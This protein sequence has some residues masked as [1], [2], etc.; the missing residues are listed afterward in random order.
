MVKAEQEYKDML[1]IG[2]SFLTV[3]REKMIAAGQRL[4]KTV[5]ELSS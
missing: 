5:R 1:G 2:L 4:A 3:R